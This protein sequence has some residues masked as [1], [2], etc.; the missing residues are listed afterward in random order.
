MTYNLS[1][2]NLIGGDDYGS[3]PYNVTF[4]AEETMAQFSVPITDD[5]LVEEE[6][7]FSLDITSTSLP[8][9]VNIGDPEKATVTIMDDDGKHNHYNC[10]IKERCS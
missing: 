10:V 3:G 2:K 5:D 4:A 7:K 8:L 6:E 1:V 9:N